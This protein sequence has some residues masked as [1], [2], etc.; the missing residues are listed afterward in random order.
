M[1]VLGAAIGNC[2]HVAGVYRFLSLAEE[3]GHEILF[4]GPAVSLERLFKEIES[5]DPDIIGVSYRLTTESAIPLLADLKNCIFERKLEKKRWLLGCTASIKPVAES[6]GFFE[7][8]FTGF[9][10][11][12]DTHAFLRGHSSKKA[13]ER[14]PQDVISRITRKTPIPILRHHFGL[15]S[16]EDTIEGVEMIADAAVLDVISVG[17]DQDAQQSF[18]R[19]REM[20]DISTGDGGVPLR[21]MDDLERIFQA[22]RRG[23]FP[24]LRCYSGTRDLLRW[25]R[26]LK[27]TINT[28]WCATPLVWYSELDGRSSRTLEAA[29]R[30]NKMNHEWHA[31]HGIPVEVNESHHWSLR[32][33]HDTIAVAMA[34]LAAYNAKAAGVHTYI[35]QY[36]LN[37]PLGLSPKMD[38]AKMLAKIELIESLNDHRFQSIRQVR[39]G[40]FSFP[41]DLDNAKG[42]LAASVYTGMLLEP[43]IVH[44][45]SF[46]EASHV[47]NANDVIE[48]CRI[49]S[50][51][52]HNCTLGNINPNQD[53]E[54]RQRK[55]ELVREANLLIRAIATFAPEDSRNPLVEPETYVGA[56]KAGVL[57][58]PHLSSN[59]IARGKLQTRLINGAC[60]AINPET[61]EPMNEI[62][63]LEKLGIILFPDIKR[64]SVF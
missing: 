12:E 63:R 6:L 50:R 38:L 46:T 64:N 56:I 53:I 61:H 44:V 45:V 3:E 51:V 16:L 14:F 26:M 34:F 30:E 5:F 41:P 4:L 7:E 37:T 32:S 57:D 25:A 9:S 49:S 55:E 35:A 52:I 36:M 15:P 54:V 59:T 40:L 23:N 39:P 10:T 33:A 42:Q 62:I 29:I 28:A 31:R 18:F 17:P 8:I 24:L 60:Y 21:S 1:R 58:A 19:P 11:D 22:T 48:S 2:V 20:T 43:Q 13:E 27:D 47:A